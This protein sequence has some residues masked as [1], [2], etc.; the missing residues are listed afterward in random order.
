MNQLMMYLMAW[1]VLNSEL[2]TIT[3]YPR[4]QFV[5]G[6]KISEARINRV[7]DY[8]GHDGTPLISEG[9]SNNIVSFYDDR[10]RTIFLQEGWSS[11]RPTEMSVLVHELVHHIQ[12]IA[13]IDY[14][15]A[16][17]REQPAY[18]AQRKWL[19]L[20]GKTLE[21]EFGIDSASLLLRT[22]CVH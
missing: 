5:A 2:P 17:E 8:V 10:T 1:L 13:K 15:C 7:K 11:T 16:A 21:G 20:F 14:L 22:K 12:N 4:I 6:G 19:S 18:A 3:E 9:A